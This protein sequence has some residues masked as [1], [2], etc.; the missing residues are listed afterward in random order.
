MLEWIVIGG[1]AAALGR[2]LLGGDKQP[3]PS[4]TLPRPNP[5]LAGVSTA[6]QERQFAS[7]LAMVE[8]EVDRTRWIPSGTADRITAKHPPPARGFDIIGLSLRLAAE[9]AGRPD[10]HGLRAKFDAHNDAFL[11]QQKVAL[12]AFFDT[13]EKSPLTDEQVEACI[14]MDDNV[15]V[16][17][18]AGSG[19][20]STMVAKA[21]YVLRQGLATP[22]QIL[23]LAFNRDAAAELGERIRD[24]LSDF[25]GIDE[26]TAKTFDGF[27]LAVI[28]EATGQKPRLAQWVSDREDIAEVA[29]I[30]HALGASDPAFKHDWDLFRTVYARDVGAASERAD[31][32]DFDGRKR[33]FRTADGKLVKSKEEL[34]IANWLF[35]NG[36]NYDYER[37]YE[38]ETA[39]E[40]HSQYQPDFFYPDIGLYHEHFALDGEGKAPAHFEGDYVA[41]VHWKRALHAE[42]GTALF[43][44]TSAEIR[45]DDA[46]RRLEEALVSGGMA[47]SFDATRKTVGPPPLTDQQ[48]ASTLRIFQQHVKSNRLSHSE[49]EQAAGQQGVLGHDYRSRLFLKLY[50][51]VAAEWERRLQQCGCIDFEDMLRMAADL[52][53]GGR[54]ES[55]FKVIFADEFQDSSRARVRLLQALTRKADDVHLTVVGDDWQGINRFAGADLRAMSEFGSFFSHSTTL[56]L[57]TTFRCPQALCDVSSEFVQANPKQLR[58]NVQSTSPFDNRPLQAFG[59]KDLAKANDHIE[60]Q[61]GHMAELLAEGRLQAG[62]GGRTTVLLLGRY[63]NDRPE[64]LSRWQRMFA[65]QLSIDFKTV[66][67]SKGLEAE[68]V[69]VLSLIEGRRGFPSQIEDDPVLQL[70]MPDA[71]TFVMAEERRLFYVALTRASRQ[72][73]L[74]TSLEKPSRFVT[75]LASQKQVVVEPVDGEA[76]ETCPKCQTGVLKLRTSGHGAFHA[77]SRYPQC[78][79]KRSVEDGETASVPAVRLAQPVALESECPT[80]GK[81]R[82]RLFDGKHGKFAGC[83]AFPSCRT[84]G[85][86]S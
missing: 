47:L 64:R 16:V 66:H 86:V 44:T 61:L 27:G 30:A 43:E 17:A 76:L 51:R 78:E 55:P 3:T 56:H 73:R 8:A 21:G 13:V 48:L 40:Q 58:K 80:C 83:S 7:W 75:E 68:Y 5:L 84:T 6:E 28:G 10:P 77:C 70:A 36:V 15:L 34:L 79:F 67:A 49:L 31:P 24:R 14:C 42:K 26:V 38:H 57:T 72:V 39:T 59:F 23:L 52:I 4:L 22:D 54:Y 9:K 71:E 19:K 1:I 41:G 18:A 60:Q 2:G 85:P 32:E 74:Y 37:A 29:D 82:M 20:T 81:G 50:E 69:Y 65:D 12:K 62:R 33:G 46:L 45:S 11:K 53:E 63:K 35:Y 25:P